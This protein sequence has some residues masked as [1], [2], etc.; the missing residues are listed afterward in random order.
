MNLLPI[1]NLFQSNS[2]LQS[3]VIIYFEFNINLFSQFFIHDK[4]EVHGSL[5][6]A[7]TVIK[8]NLKKFQVLLLGPDSKGKF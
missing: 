3:E 1:V 6:L 5:V 7:G 4:F 8:G 2:D